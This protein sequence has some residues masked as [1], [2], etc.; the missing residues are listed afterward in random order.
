M[1]QHHHMYR[2]LNL[3]SPISETHKMK[4]LGMITG[5]TAQNEKIKN[6]RFKFSGVTLESD[7]LKQV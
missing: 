7:R 3:K 4:D 2:S 5:N 1:S 6:D